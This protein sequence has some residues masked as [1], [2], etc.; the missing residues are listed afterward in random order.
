MIGFSIF[1]IGVSTSWTSRDGP[2]GSTVD[3]SMRGC[4]FVVPLIVSLRSFVR[5]AYKDEPAI[6]SVTSR[7][8]GAKELDAQRRQRRLVDVDVDF[9]Y[10]RVIDRQTDHADESS[11]GE[12]EDRRAAI[13]WLRHQDDAGPCPETDQV[14]RYPIGP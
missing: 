12:R 7:L 13:P 9:G 2:T 6:G 10:A 4:D 11:L 3:A 8:F 1:V 14:S 5:C